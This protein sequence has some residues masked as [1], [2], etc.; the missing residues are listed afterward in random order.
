MILHRNGSGCL[1]VKLNQQHTQCKDNSSLHYL[2][3]NAA[4]EFRLYGNFH[5]ILVPGLLDRECSQYL[6]NH[7]PHRQIRKVSPDADAPAEPECDVFAVTGFER[8]VVSEEAL[9]DKFVGV[10]VLGF[11]VGH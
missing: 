5:P 6:D 3:G 11:I 10:W 4:G 8:A 1:P 9:G 7:R 2:H